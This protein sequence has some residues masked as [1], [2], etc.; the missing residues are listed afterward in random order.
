VATE[1]L[2]QLESEIHQNAPHLRQIE[3]G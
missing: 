1:E 2:Y 3:S